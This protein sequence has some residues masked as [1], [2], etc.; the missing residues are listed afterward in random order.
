VFAKARFISGDVTD[1]DKLSTDILAQYIKCTEEPK[2]HSWEPGVD[3]ARFLLASDSSDLLG[4]KLRK[5][6]ENVKIF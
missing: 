1:T 5:L 3:T 4:G 6:L 2:V